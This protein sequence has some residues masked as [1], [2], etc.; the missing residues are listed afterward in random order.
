MSIR[1]DTWY[2][3]FRHPNGL[4][5]AYARASRTFATELEAK[6]FAAERLVDGCDDVTAGTLNPHQPKRI[7]G[8]SQLPRWL[9]IDK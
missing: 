5:E 7:I 2:V 8:S 6:Q 4:P 9:G 1:R 3:A